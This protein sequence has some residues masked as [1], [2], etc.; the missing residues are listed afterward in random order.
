MP[1]SQGSAGGLPGLNLKAWA[2]VSNAGVLLRGFGV[3]SASRVAAGSYQINLQTP[4]VGRGVMRVT[5]EHSGY[6]SLAFLSSQSIVSVS[7]NNAAGAATDAY[8]YIE[9]YD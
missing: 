2:Q 5:A 6:F 3:T 8:F 4:L 9:V 7:T 1:V